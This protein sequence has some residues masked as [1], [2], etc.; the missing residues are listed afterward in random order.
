MVLEIEPSATLDIKP[1]A[2]LDI[3]EDE[4]AFIIAMG[5]SPEGLFLNLPICLEPGTRTCLAQ[6][7]HGEC[8]LLSQGIGSV[9]EVGKK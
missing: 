8:P 3:E 1:S 2:T 6:R 5:L 7:L 4:V 9:E